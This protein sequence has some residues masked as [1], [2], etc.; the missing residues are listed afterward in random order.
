[1]TKNHPEIEDKYAVGPED[2]LPE[3]GTLAE[4]ASVSG[5]TQQDLEATYFD[6]A[7]LTL[8]TVGITVRR[9]AGGDDAGWHV[10]LPTSKGRYEVHAP[11]GRSRTTV[12]KRLRDL[13]MASVREQGLAPIAKVSTHRT[14]RWLTDAGGRV[15]AEVADDGVTTQ[16]LGHDGNVVSSTAWREWEVELVEGG[17]PLLRSAAE[18]FRKN[19]VAPSE[20]P[21]KLV[22]AL[23]GRMPARPPHPL[24]TKK[25]A[26]PT[27]VVRAWLGKQ[28]AQLRR[29]DPLVRADAPDA[30]HKM[31]VATRRLRSALATF[32][33]LLERELTDPVRAELK[34]IA[35][36]L[37]EARDAEVMRERLIEMLTAAD[38]QAVSGAAGA[39]VDRIL[40]D[41]YKRAHAACVRA[42]TSER[43]LAL[44][45]RLDQL[46]EDPPWTKDA[47]HRST[48]VLR[49]RV[50]HAWKRLARRVRAVEDTNG[51]DER[52]D[53]MHEVR[54]AAKRVRYAAEPLAPQYGKA[55]K[56]FVEVTKRVQSVLGDHQ[57]SVVTQEELR[58][59]ADAAVTDG[60]DSFTFG[61][62]HA[63]EDRN[64][65]DT[66][67]HV[68]A[69]WAKASKKKHRNWLT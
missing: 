24:P 55:A 20:S 17:Q 43:Y 18:L 60:D 49:K 59:L 63:H 46:L 14:V 69:A 9:R 66:E 1:M 62:L 47:H 16:A 30:V 25:S 27:E 50:A 68:W 5:L 23:D 56:R 2:R 28:V 38:P 52:A 13:L 36:V 64:Q 65:D 48:A 7:A 54:K 22:E 67:K 19:G 61:V 32:R 37:G 26:P 15:L 35:G 39:R 21:S 44:L 41:R 34:W 53:A 33:P 8:T 45:E 31:R 12:P 11:L 4:V 10:K 40:S 58:K 51:E 57:D 29:Q 3:L 6:T 42:M